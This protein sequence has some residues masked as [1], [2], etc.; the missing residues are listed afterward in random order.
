MSRR[1]KS[2][3][4]KLLALVGALLLIVGLVAG[5]MAYVA[6]LKPNVHTKKDFTYLYIPTGSTFDDVKG[7]LLQEGLI[8]N[9]KT[10]EWLARKKN[11]PNRVMAGRYK[12]YDDM[13]NNDLINLL[14]SGVQEPVNVTFNNIRTRE[15]LAGAVAGYLEADSLELLHLLNDEAVMQEYGQSRET[16]MLLFIPDTYEFFWNTSAPQVLKRMHREYDAFWNSRRRRQ[17]ERIGMSP[18]EVAIM[19]SIVRQETSKRDEME[20]IAGVYVN[21]IKGNIPLQ[22]DP[23]IVFAVGDFSLNRV[24]NRHLEIDS[25]YNT[26]KY[27]GLPP[28]PI[29]LP[30]PYII[31]A[32]LNYE[33]HEYVFFCARDDFSGYHAFAKT[34]AEHL[35]NARRY[36]QAL[37][38]RRIMR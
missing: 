18:V 5:Y 12:I 24:L 27:A 7:I 3:I 28:G 16:A 8:D 29:S 2:R 26:Y 1:K 37:N 14:R 22:A 13:G 32:V 38:K 10:F 31:D 11:Y 15:Q 19:A 25:P 23:T 35:V 21:R 36:Q 30:E 4:V 20:R 17:A 33:H 9:E 34:Y 6:I